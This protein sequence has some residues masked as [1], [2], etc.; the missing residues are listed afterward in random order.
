MTDEKKHEEPA[1]QVAEE[2]D[3]VVARTRAEGA[4]KVEDK[5]VGEKVDCHLPGLAVAKAELVGIPEGLGPPGHGFSEEPESIV[6]LEMV[7]V[8]VVSRLAVVRA[9]GGVGYA[10]VEVAGHGPGAHRP[11]NEEN[12]GNENEARGRSCKQI[13]LLGREVAVLY[14]MRGNV[15]IPRPPGY[16]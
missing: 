13:F 10:L 3:R 11:E 7:P 5:G 2:E 4:E 16:P 14:P 15:S 9:I 6:E 8:N 12:G 1:E